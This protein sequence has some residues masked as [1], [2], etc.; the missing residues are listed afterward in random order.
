MV[1]FNLR[2]G[3]RLKNVF[4]PDYYFAEAFSVSPSFLLSRGIGVLILDIDNTLVTYADAY[5]TEAV[6]KWINAMKQGGVRLAIASN[7]HGKR[8]DTF[9]ESLDVFT[10]SDSNKPSRKAVDVICR[11]F[12]ITPDKAAVI[13]DQ[14]FTDVLCAN[15]A[16]AVAILVKPLPYR[17]NLFFK[18]KRLLEKPIIKKFKHKH[19]DKCFAKGE[20]E[21]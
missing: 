6:T 15:R 18:F 5:P 3:M 10:V 19:P 13:G 20:N 8:V 12:S 1:I 4:E 2:R 16:G 21:K 11:R 7:N 17:E 9:A 14:I